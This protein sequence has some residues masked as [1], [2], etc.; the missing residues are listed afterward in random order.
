VSLSC[1]AVGCRRHRRVL[2]AEVDFALGAG[3]AL[4]VVGP[5]GSGKTTLLR[6][7]AGLGRPDR[8]RVCW[9]GRDVRSAETPYRNELLYVGH[10]A[11]VDDLL[12]PCENLV[13]LDLLAGP[14]AQRIA[15]AALERAGLADQAGTPV[16]LLSQGQRRRV[17][18][19]RIHLP[20]RRQVW[21]MDEPFNGLDAATTDA[22]STAL[23][24]HRASGGIV[25][26][27]THVDAGPA[28]ACRLQ[29]GVV[30]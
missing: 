1:H 27:A 25:I 30:P 26:Y 7:L 16:R 28:D 14:D 23:A 13:Y 3:D 9:L 18:L 24:A 21:I 19:A 29:L 15:L 10:S 6:V 22:L 8:G 20:C 17:A 5:N 2:F 11:G 12:T 4:R